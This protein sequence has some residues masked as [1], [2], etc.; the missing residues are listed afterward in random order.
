MT[1]DSEQRERNDREPKASLPPPPHPD[2]EDAAWLGD[3]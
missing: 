3:P 2:V 1:D